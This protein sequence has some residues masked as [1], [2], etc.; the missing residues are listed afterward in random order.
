[1]ILAGIVCGCLTALI[2]AFWQGAPDE[3]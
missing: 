1:A 2:Q 3:L